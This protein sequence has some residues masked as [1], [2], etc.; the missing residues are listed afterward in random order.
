[1]FGTLIRTIPVLLGPLM[2]VCMVGTLR[3]YDEYT[4]EGYGFYYYADSYDDSTNCHA[5]DGI[6]RVNLATG[7]E[8][9]IFGD[10]SGRYL[11]SRCDLGYHGKQLIFH[12]ASIGNG[13]VNNDGTGYRKLSAD[14][15]LNTPK[16]NIH[17][18]RLGV[19]TTRKGKL[20]R[21]DVLNGTHETVPFPTIPGWDDG[22]FKSGGDLICLASGDGTR[23]WNR[24]Y[25]KT[26]GFGPKKYG[27]P[28]VGGRTVSHSYFVL[29]DDGTP[30]LMHGR[31]FWGHGDVMTLDGKQLYCQDFNHEGWWIVRHS[32]GQKIADLQRKDLPVPAPGFHTACLKEGDPGVTQDARRPMQHCTNDND[33]FYFFTAPRFFGLP[34]KQLDEAC[35]FNT[36]W[37]RKTNTYIKVH[38]P[39]DGAWLPRCRSTTAVQCA[40]FWKGSDL[41]DVNEAGAY[42]VAYR[43]NV[44]FHC[45]RQ[46]TP[47]EKTVRI[48]NIDD[49]ALEEVT[50]TVEPHTATSW[51]TPLLDHSN[52]S[53]TMRPRVN[54]GALPDGDE[55]SATITVQASSARNTA[56]VA[57]HV[58]KTM[59][60][61]PADFVVY[62]ANMS[63]SF[64]YPELT[65]ED[66]ADGE[67][68]YIVEFHNNHG[69]WTPLDTL[70]ANTER[71]I[72]RLHTHTEASKSGKYRL[73]AFTTGAVYS[74]WSDEGYFCVP[75][76]SMV[77]PDPDW[78]DEGWS[79]PNGGAADLDPFGKA[80]TAGSRM[81]TVTVTR[82][83]V[84]IGTNAGTF[85]G[86][87][88]VI[89][90]DGRC[91]VNRT[92]GRGSGKDR[93]VP[94]PRWGRGVCVVSLQ[95][96]EGN[97]HTVRRFVTIR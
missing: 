56:S 52:V 70:D 1:M 34:D 13:I 67:D 5:R 41:P 8:K 47:L 60:P 90:P 55:H 9:Q 84:V 97:V 79:A 87:L 30:A 40:G 77:P 85:R 49:A 73:R 75:P 3:A 2:L 66:R 38:G 32:D 24:T 61:R 25:Y 63:D 62:H 57:V 93:V 95:D 17:W 23:L 19:F 29:N 81:P 92:I 12:G 48:G 22:S 39:M 44:T 15:P 28:K 59:L 10:N 72:S 20:L 94:L 83:A 35:F 89:R 37:N 31:N 96:A 64:A 26:I 65:W 21:W 69:T 86:V 53:I 18:T 33:W 6:W 45:A 43:K 54:P 91:L 27:Y 11:I 14:L 88:R 78:V 58:D 76:D 51:L 80:A 68:G 71:Y 42:L 16:E 36:V 4:F 74:P 50:A 7:E 82:R 46:T